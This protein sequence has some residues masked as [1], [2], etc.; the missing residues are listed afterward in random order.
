MKTT[1]YR[2]IYCLLN[3]SFFSI[4]LFF[5]GKLS[6][7]STNRIDESILGDN[8]LNVCHWNSKAKERP[9]QIKGT[10]KIELRRWKNCIYYVESYECARAR[11]YWLEWAASNEISRIVGDSL[12]FKIVWFWLFPHWLECHF[13]SK[14]FFMC[15]IDIFRNKSR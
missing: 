8:N 15:F 10:N 5:F 1:S 12:S 13:I 6:L 11:L 14:F 3:V 4:R 7:S 2:K 9:K